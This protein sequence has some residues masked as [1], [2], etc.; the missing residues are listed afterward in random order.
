MFQTE[1]LEVRHVS[2]KGLGVFA[3]RPFEQG[4]V[5]E[6]APIIVVIPP[7]QV[8]LIEATDILEYYY[9]WGTD[10]RSAAIA[11]GFGSFYNHSPRPNARIVREHAQGRLLVVALERIRAGEEITF[12]YRAARDDE[13]LGF[14]PI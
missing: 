5:V 13:P 12:D 11:G 6:A 1:D 14:E 8:P 10:L 7:E 3:R 9:Y 4:D 2:V